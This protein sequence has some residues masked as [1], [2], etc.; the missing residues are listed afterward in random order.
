MEREDFIQVNTNHFTYSEADVMKRSFVLSFRTRR[1]EKG[2]RVRSLMS[3][4]AVVTALF[5]TM[6]G[7]VLFAGGF[8]EVAVVTHE[9]AGIESITR[10]ELSRL[11]LSRTNKVRGVRL[12]PVNLANYGLKLGF[13]NQLTGM[14]PV[15]IENHFV[16]MEL[17]GEGGWPLQVGTAR[18]LAQ[19]I[20]QS[21]RAIGWIPKS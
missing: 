19:L 15:R 11:F 7:S 5:T 1:P 21:R 14:S 16:K 6:P 9:S 4:L 10:V 13:L 20:G 17:R 18:E 3:L 12:R 8:T 2:R